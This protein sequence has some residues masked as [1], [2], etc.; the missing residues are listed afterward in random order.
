[1]NK[2]QKV[3]MNKLIKTY[4]GLINEGLLNSALRIL[5]D[6]KGFTESIKDE[7]ILNELKAYNKLK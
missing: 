1:M 7:K 2:E 4:K 3:F 5:E 6:L